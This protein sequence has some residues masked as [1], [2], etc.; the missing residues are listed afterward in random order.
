MLFE[1]IF[2]R[3]A[4][5]SP[6]TVITRAVLEYALNPK[7]LDEVFGKHAVKQYEGKL[8]F[9]SV[10]DVMSLAVCR[11]QPSVKTAYEAMKDTL[12]VT[13]Q[14]FYDKLNG[15][16]P[17]VTS[18]MVRHVGSRL[19]PVIKEMGGELPPPL[20]GYRARIIDGNHLAATDRRLAVLRESKVPALPGHSLVILDPE[21][22]LAI[23]MIPCADG[24]AQERTLFAQV[25]S[26]VEPKDLWIGDRNFCT[27]GFLQGVVAR[28]GSFIIRQHAKLT[29]ASA[30]ALRSRGRC[31]TGRVSE[32]AVTIVGEDGKDIKLRRIVLHLDKPTGEGDLVIS[33]LTN[34]PA[35]AAK[36][37]RIADIYR[38]RWSIEGLFLR[39]T[40]FL[41]GEVPSLGH[42]CAA[43]FDFGVALVSYNVAATLRAALHVK[44]GHEKVEEEVSWYY[45][46]NEVR[47]VSGGMDLAI[48]D[49]TWLRF[50]AMSPQELAPELLTYAA[51]VRLDKFTRSKRGPKKPPPKRT[52]YANSSHVSTGQLLVRAGHHL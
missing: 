51:H 33:I 14:A 13:L 35:S 15:I 20:P 34:V 27:A 50:Q 7:T 9:S 22:G 32:Q 39:L 48:D 3:F 46:A 12:P 6:V 5:K 2:D 49:S 10:V 19:A 26:G 11:V 16:E 44:F 43:L 29:I 25:L 36:A 17:A 38:E 40:Q 1:S 31:S 24:H 8:L 41:S 23:D 4:K 42:P 45:V 28:G 21:L 37:A 30:G 18:A 47:V 52:L